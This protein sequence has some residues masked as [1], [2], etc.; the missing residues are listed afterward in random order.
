MKIYRAYDISK[1][2]DISNKSA[3]KVLFIFNSFCKSTSKTIEV[4]GVDTE[5]RAL[6]QNLF[7]QMKTGNAEP[8]QELY[9]KYFGNVIG[10]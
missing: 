9:I 10:R 8:S 3:K 7:E 2:Y 1:K 4:S 6:A 5:E